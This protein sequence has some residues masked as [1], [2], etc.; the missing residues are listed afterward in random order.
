MRQHPARPPR[1]RDSLD[2]NTDHPPPFF[3]T[4]PPCARSPRVLHS[5]RSVACQFHYTQ[6]AETAPRPPPACSRLAPLLGFA[7]PYAAL[8]P[9]TSPARVVR[10]LGRSASS[11]PDTGNTPRTQRAPG[12][13]AYSMP[14]APA[15]FARYRRLAAFF[16]S[17]FCTTAEKTAVPTHAWQTYFEGPRPRTQKQGPGSTSEPQR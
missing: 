6:W 11:C 4:L 7:T 8:A 13:R 15:R 5:L 2:S 14:L 12:G 10:S 3:A 9:V 17:C 1:A 16:S